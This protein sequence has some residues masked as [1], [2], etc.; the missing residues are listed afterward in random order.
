MVTRR[1]P[2]KTYAIILHRFPHSFRRR[3]HSANVRDDNKP[4][5]LPPLTRESRKQKMAGMG[6]FLQRNFGDYRASR[7]RL[8]DFRS[9][10]CTASRRP[11][12]S[13]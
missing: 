6:Q 3:Q 1:P 11:S 12:S 5:P 10:F 8:E 7:E 13:W 4:A 2:L 9:A